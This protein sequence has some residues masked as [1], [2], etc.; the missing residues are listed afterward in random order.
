[1]CGSRQLT[2]EVIT[3]RE[4][5]LLLSVGKVESRIEAVSAHE[6]AGYNWWS[7]H[8]LSMSSSRRGREIE[9]QHIGPTA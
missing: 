1:M 2:V 4:D 3:V 8:D 9:L 5:L 7:S 6:S